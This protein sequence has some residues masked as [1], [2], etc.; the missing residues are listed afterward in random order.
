MKRCILLATAIV[1][2]IVS[3]DNTVSEEPQEVAKNIE[4]LT[5]DNERLEIYNTNSIG[6]KSSSI[7]G[8]DLPSSIPSGAIEL[9]S[10]TKIE[11]NKTY[12]I[13]SSASIE[14]AIDFDEKI[15]LYLQGHLT[16][17]RSLA[18]SN[19]STIFIM[20][21][22]T[23]QIKDDTK[24]SGI[25]IIN[26]GTIVFKDANFTIE[27]GLLYSLNDLDFGLKNLTLTNTGQL[28][29][30]GTLSANNIVA[31]GKTNPCITVDCAYV[32]NKITLVSSSASQMVVNTYLEAKTLLIQTKASL[33][34]PNPGTHVYVTDEILVRSN[35]IILAS[36]SDYS[37]ITTNKLTFRNKNGLKKINGNIDF[38]YETLYPSNVNANATLKFNEDTYIA[39]CDCGGQEVGTDSNDNE[40]WVL[41]TIA[42]LNSV[43]TLKVSATGIAFR[44]DEFLV[45]WHLN[46]RFDNNISADDDAAYK[47]YVDFVT[48]NEVVDDPSNPIYEMNI[49]RTWH[50]PNYDFNHIATVDNKTYIAGTEFSR[51][52]GVGRVPN[53]VVGEVKDAEESFIAQIIKN[54]STANCVISAGNNDLIGLSGGK[55]GSVTEVNLDEDE[56]I[57]TADY[58]YAKYLAQK[59]D[60]IYTLY[61]VKNTPRIE[62]INDSNDGFNI[63]AITPT[64][65]KNAFKVDGEK[66]YIPMGRNG[67][68]VYENGNLLQ[69]Y[70]HEEEFKSLSSTTGQI[71]YHTLSCVDVDE[72]YIYLAYGKVGLYI[73]NKANFL[74]NTEPILAF[75]YTCQ[76]IEDTEGGIKSAN[77]VRVKEGLIYV[78]YG[79]DGVYVFKIIKIAN[80]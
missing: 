54:Q 23:L 45:S 6:L 33:E 68:Q 7:T 70:K 18:S 28:E 64:D 19:S 40:E 51:L 80:E 11:K 52:E 57:S 73:L 17:E 22:G 36:T 26:A 44:G 53:A 72:D 5:I 42:K 75:K 41:K 12:Y 15:T 59:G 2:L 48:G 9:N 76:D 61:D 21:N 31:K 78:A 25:D 13:P 58:P 14:R 24:M 55:N 4:A 35:A 74:S 79:I 71:E 66:F 50:A 69:S 56:L 3:C 63:G 10:T 49:N 34:L 29:C 20:E 67:L 65:G 37:L 39:A 27:D 30:K 47:G 1:A 43:D 32:T 60:N 16:L 38:H 62:N 8:I 77:F 46:E